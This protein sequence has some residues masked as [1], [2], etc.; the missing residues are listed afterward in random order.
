MGLIRA[1]KPINSLEVLTIL[2]NPL[3]SDPEFKNYIYRNLENLKYLDYQ[4]IDAN[5]KNETED[6]KYQANFQNYEEN[7]EKNKI[8]GEDFYE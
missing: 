4:F 5:L 1:L 8:V 3:T 2:H 7:L 6:Y